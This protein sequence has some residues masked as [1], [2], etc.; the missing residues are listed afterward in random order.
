MSP[1]E[2]GDPH[3]V[4]A[5]LLIAA[6]AVPDKNC[7]FRLHTLQR[8]LKILGVITPRRHG[9]TEEEMGASIERKLQEDL[10]GRWGYRK[11]QEK[12]GLQG[13]LIPQCVNSICNDDNQASHA[14]QSLY[15]L[16]N[17]DWIAAYL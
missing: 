8:S 11:V 15:N 17:S 5:Q 6:S 4:T 9:L 1:R 10:L 7:L 14:N 3:E 2:E 16:N 13:I 12:L